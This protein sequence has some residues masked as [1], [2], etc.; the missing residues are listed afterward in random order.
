MDAPLQTLSSEQWLDLALKFLES[1]IPFIGGPW[2]AIGAAICQLIAFLV[3]Q[4]NT[5]LGRMNREQAASF[6]A[7]LDAVLAAFAAQR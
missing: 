7:R 3:R 1:L 6:D 2:G 5:A 4:H